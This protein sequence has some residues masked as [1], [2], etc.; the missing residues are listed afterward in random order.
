[1]GRGLRTVLITV[2]AVVVIAVAAALLVIYTGGYNVAATEGHWA[3]TE[4]ALHTLQER[5]VAARAGE[6][7]VPIPADPAA[8]DEGFEHFHAMCVECHGAPGF[9][10]GELGQGLNPRP[11]RLER[12]A[13]EW[14]DAELFWITKHGIRFAGMPAFGS[15]HSDE[16]IAAIVGF[17]RRL[18]EMTE[19]EYA[20][21]V[22]ALE[23]GAEGAGE[24][25]GDSAAGHTHAPGTP[26]HEH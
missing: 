23:G 1:M 19:V 10:R 22:R 4:W 20:D 17:L 9:D 25:P 7:A 5:S 8:L 3:I 18:E 21:R 2:A 15:T 6:L 11:P 13:E 14:S 24:S 12:E 16:T 26:E